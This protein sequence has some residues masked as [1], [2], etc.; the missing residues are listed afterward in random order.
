MQWLPG[1]DDGYFL[2]DRTEFYRSGM[3]RRDGGRRAQMRVFLMLDA[4]KF[5][6]LRAPRTNGKL[7]GD[8]LGDRAGSD[9]VSAVSSLPG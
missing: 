2:A 8:R 1:R 6:A 9:R 5:L 4:G 3:A 7:V